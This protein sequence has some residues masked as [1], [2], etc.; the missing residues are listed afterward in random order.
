MIEVVNKRTEETLRY[1]RAK[2]RVHDTDDPALREYYR[3]IIKKYEAKHSQK[4]VSAPV[5]A[6]SGIQR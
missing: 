4:K 5:V 3:E 2:Y 6:F 1:E